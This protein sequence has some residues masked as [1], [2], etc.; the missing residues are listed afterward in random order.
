MN[1]ARFLT[2]T[3]ARATI[4]INPDNFGLT[5]SSLKSALA[6]DKLTDTGT[7]SPFTLD[8]LRLYD[9]IYLGGNNL[10]TAEEIALIVYVKAGGGVYVAAG[11]GNITGG[12]AG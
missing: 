9:A 11:T 1:S 10:T 6:A 3:T 4:R 5:G 2:G 7:F 8:D 12:A